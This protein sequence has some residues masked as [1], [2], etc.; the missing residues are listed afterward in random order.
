MEAENDRSPSWVFESNALGAY[1]NSS[2]RSDLERGPKA[3]NIRPPRASRDRP[4]DR[5]LLFFGNVPSALGGEF[6][7]AMGLLGIA[8]KSQGIDVRVGFLNVCDGFAGEKGWEPLLPEL[9]FTFDFALGLRG[10]GIK[11]AYL[12][13]GER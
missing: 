6:E 7:F 8:M 4:Q 3:P 5:A 12:V 1:W 2:I 13:E 9:V 10:W 11:E